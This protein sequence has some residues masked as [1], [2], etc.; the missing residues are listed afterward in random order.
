MVYFVDKYVDLLIKHPENACFKGVFDELVKIIV[1]SV[2][3]LYCSDGKVF[4]RITRQKLFELHSTFSLR[5]N[6]CYD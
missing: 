2:K 1:K 5:L 4:D 3:Y 6:F